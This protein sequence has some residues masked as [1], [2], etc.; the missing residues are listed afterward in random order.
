[1]AI[2]T[3]EDFIKLMDD[4]I[5]IGIFVFNNRKNGYYKDDFF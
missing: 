3:K 4:L 5:E 2:K 1:M